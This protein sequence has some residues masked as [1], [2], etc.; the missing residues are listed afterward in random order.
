MKR[1]DLIK[2]GI[3]ED[4]VDKIMAIHGTDIESHK[5]KLTTAETAL[6]AAQTELDGTKKQLTE[7]GV[8]IESFKKLDVEGVKKAADEWKTK[9][10]QAQAEAAKQV[11][12]LKFDHALDG[13]LTGA[14]AKNAKA[15]KALLNADLLKLADDGTISGLKEQIEKI[16]S[17]NDF[18]FQGETPDP[19]IVLGGNNQ[20]VTTD[21][22]TA[23]VRKGAGLPDKG[24]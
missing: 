21:A 9:A 18:L 7:A 5:S 10:E 11:A 20:T 1:E 6:T 8:Q 3:A 16:K 2:L 15:V 13:A 24:K 12:Q 23:A 19:K 4:V 14:K 17:E 22:F